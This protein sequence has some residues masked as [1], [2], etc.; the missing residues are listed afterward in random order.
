MPFCP[1]CQNPYNS[2]DEVCSNC[3]SILPGSTAILQPGTVLH[4]KYEIEKLFHVGGMGY[5][6]LARDK[7][8]A[9]RVC[10]I[11]QIKES[12]NSDPETLGKL[13]NEALTMAKL[14][15]PNVA[16]VFEHFVENNYYFL[17]VE[18]IV[19]KTLSEIFTERNGQL[20]EKEVVNWAISVCDVLSYIHSQGVIHRDISP[21]N[22]MVT[23][24]GMVKFID[25]G[26]MREMRYIASRGTAGMGKIGYTPPEQWIGRPMPQSDVFALA[27]TIYYLLAGYLPLTD[28]YLKGQGV[29]G[30]DFNPDFP[31][32]RT[33]NPAISLELE[34]IMEKALQL[35][36][37]R[38][39]GS[40][41]EFREALEN[42]KSTW[43][44]EVPIVEIYPERVDFKAVK[45]GGVMTS[46]LVL[47][48]KGA[49]RL[50]GKLVSSQAWLKVSPNIIDTDK[51]ETEITVTID[52]GNT[53]LDHTAADISITTNG[54]R[55]KVLVNIGDVA[56]DQSA[57]TPSRTPAKTN[58]KPVFLTVGLVV[59]VLIIGALFFT[60]IP[61]SQSASGTLLI[62]GKVAEKL[63]SMTRD[64]ISSWDKEIIRIDGE[65]TQAEIKLGKLKQ[66]AEPALKWVD[67]MKTKAIQEQW[68]GRVLEVTSDLNQIKNDQFRIAKLQ[69]L[70]EMLTAGMRYSSIIQIDDLI[71][72]QIRPY[73]ELLNILQTQVTTLSQKREARARTRNTA[74]STAVAVFDTYPNWNEQKVNDVTYN[75]TGQGLGLETAITMGTWTYSTDSEELK[76]VGAAATNLRRVLTGN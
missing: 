6:Y 61:G 73:E 74:R 12:T 21:D 9:D 17:V 23:K 49:G 25:F 19:G 69:F 3:G 2:G 44:Q 8:L 67:L 43:T 64:A 72:G 71:S 51:E 28:E 22:I 26:T 27:A 57:T 76:P 66:V 20:T 29:Q 36:V 62:Q 59:L 38:R 46:T 58:K 30:Q 39:Y 54:G 5:V 15:H 37:N 70:V 7:T 53:G 68:N 75:L 24:E 10:I 56:A 16:T 14:N 55:T 11:K 45:P 47:K 35:G 4:G 32:I 63:T 42:L 41:Q 48:N 65:L 52:P 13:Q 33:K 1:S 60:I 18:Y 40:V 31:P 50:I 34:Q